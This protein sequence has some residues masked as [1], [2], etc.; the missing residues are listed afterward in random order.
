MKKFTALIALFTVFILCFSLLSF[1]IAE[2]NEAEIEMINSILNKEKEGDGTDVTE[3]QNKN[4]KGKVTIKIY[5]GN[6]RS[7]SYNP[8]IQM[9][10]DTRYNGL[11]SATVVVT[12]SKG[13]TVATGK[14]DSNGTVSFSLPYGEYTARP[15]KKGYSIAV[16]GW[17]MKESTFTLN[18]SNKNI[19]CLFFASPVASKKISASLRVY[20]YSRRSPDYKSNKKLYPDTRYMGLSGAKVVVKKASDKSVFATVYTN[21][22]GIAKVELNEGESYIVTVTKSGYDVEWVGRLVSNSSASNSYPANTTEYYASAKGTGD[23]G[24]FYAK[25]A[26]GKIQ[27]TTTNEDGATILEGAV[28]VVKNEKNKVVA[29]LTSNSNGIASTGYIA[30]GGYKIIKKTA[31]DGYAF[32]SESA[33]TVEVKADAKTQKITVKCKKSTVTINIKTV[34]AYTGK[35]MKN[36]P[37]DIWSVTQE[38]NGSTSV[39][40]KDNVKTNK[41]GTLTIKLPVTNSKQVYEI[42]V[43]DTPKGYAS[44]YTAKTFTANKSKTVT[45]EIL[46]LFTCKVKVLDSNGKPVKDAEVSICHSSAKTNKNGV[47]TVKDVE[48]GTNNVRV[49]INENGHTYIAYDKKMAF[50][51]QSGKVISQ[52]INLNKRSAW[53]EQVVFYVA[54]KPIIYL[55]S[56]KE[57]GVN[58]RLGY[59]ENLS[60]VYPAYN[61]NG[62][63]VTVH[64]N[65]M[66]TDKNTGRNLYSLYWEGLNN[67]CEMKE[68]GFVVAGSDTV[69]FLEDKLAYLGLTEREAEEFIVFWLP[70][71]QGNAYNYIRFKT[72]EEINEVMPLEITPSA[73]KVVRVWMEYKPLTEKIEIQE[74]EL[75]QID[76]SELEKLDF[77]AVEWGGTEF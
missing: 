5:D 3:L 57:Q 4:K 45:V 30:P 16:L 27:I 60:A 76:R 19:K 25:P 66:L 9:A 73:D 24:L 37:M 32:K 34:D 2:E 36:I 51:A 10:P 13:E 35:P 22:N 49:T 59:P 15:S 29:T 21:S 46:P 65:G 63:D 74:Q 53:T 62:W 77:Y 61:E 44:Y 42:N 23:I 40:V 7:A 38:D 41:N 26:T 72:E 43:G 69:S 56:K 28:Y 64:T 12:N 39:C 14:T 71:M 6:S 68:D 48:F 20:D 75:V 11:V 54:M 55:Y 31:P 67:N 18:S 70:R 50:K 52:T 33:V 17:Y 47:A 8:N 1:S 58:V